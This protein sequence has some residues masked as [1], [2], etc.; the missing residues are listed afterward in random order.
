MLPSNS[1]VSSQLKGSGV[2]HKGGTMNQKDNN[3]TLYIY[4]Y[5]TVGTKP[6]PTRHLMLLS[7]RLL[8]SSTNTQ[9]LSR[10]CNTFL[11]SSVAFSRLVAR[12]LC[13]LRVRLE[14]T[15]PVMDWRGDGGEWVSGEEW[16]ERALPGRILG[17]LRLEDRI[18]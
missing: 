7:H 16:V 11:Y 8:P 17:I 6:L 13:I 9:T 18:L 15:E 12:Y 1:T 4:S 3:S 5:K 2:I 10:G 14:L